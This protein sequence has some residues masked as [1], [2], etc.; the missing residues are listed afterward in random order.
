[1]ES[2]NVVDQR[3]NRF[4]EEYGNEKLPNAVTVRI[5]VT[6]YALADLHLP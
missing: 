1:V 3:Q 6:M 5:V 2:Y 4:D